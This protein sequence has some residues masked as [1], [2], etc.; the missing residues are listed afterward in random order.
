M[1]AESGTA[2]CY[3]VDSATTPGTPIYSSVADLFCT[4]NSLPRP[5][6]T[7]C[8][9]VEGSCD[10]TCTSPS[11]SVPGSC[12]DDTKWTSCN[13]DT[14]SAVSST[15]SAC[16]VGING[17]FT[18]NADAKYCHGVKPV[19]RA[20]A[21]CAAQWL[22]TTGAADTDNPVVCGS[23]SCSCQTGV[24][25]TAGGT[26]HCYI[27]G[28]AG[29][30]EDCAA[31]TPRP[32]EPGAD[33]TCAPKTCPILCRTI[34]TGDPP[35]TQLVACSGTNDALFGSCPAA[36]QCG[37]AIIEATVV[38]TDGAGAAA[39]NG[40]T[41]CDDTP[42]PV[43]ADTERACS[44]YTG[45]GQWQCRPTVPGSSGGSTLG[46]PETCELQCSAGCGTG[47]ENF[48]NGRPLCIVWTSGAGGAEPT[49]EVK[50]D[51]DAFCP[52]ENTASV[53]PVDA[54]ACTNHTECSFR[55][56]APDA[57]PTTVP[58]VCSAT[59]ATQFGPCVATNQCGTG[60]ASTSFACF[61]ERAQA[62]TASDKDCEDGAVTP[63]IAPS[64]PCEVFTGCGAW[65]CATQPPEDDDG[66]FVP[67]LATCTLECPIGCGSAVQVFTNGAPVCVS[68]DGTTILS[69]A[70][71]I[72]AFCPEAN[73]DDVK[74]ALKQC[75]D[76][77]QCARYC[78]LP[79][80][81]TPT[82]A[83]A[84]ADPV[85]CTDLTAWLPCN[86]AN[87]C[88]AGTLETLVV[89]YDVKY[90]E[91]RATAECAAV[92]DQ[93]SNSPCTVYEGCG[94][95]RCRT[96]T[97]ALD[98]CVAS[99][100]AGC[101]PST[102]V[103]NGDVT[104]ARQES[105]DGAWI[106]ASATE[107]CPLEN[108]APPTEQQCLSTSSCVWQ[109]QLAD[110]TLGT[111]DPNTM[112]ECTDTKWPPCSA[113]CGFGSRSRFVDCY[114]PAT[115][116][117]PSQTM[118]D[119]YC[120]ATAAPAET[121]TCE[122]FAECSFG[123]RCAATG[124]AT[125][126]PCDND[127]KFSICS[128]DCG[129][130]EQT[131]EVACFDHLDNRRDDK[132]CTAN[133][134]LAVQAC[135]GTTCSYAWGCFSGTPSLGACT[136]ENA[137]WG[138]CSATC[139]TGSRTRSTA[140]FTTGG[141]LLTSTASCV[142]DQDLAVPVTED[143]NCANYS[144]CKWAYSDWT[145]CPCRA[146]PTAPAPERSRT[147]TCTDAAGASASTDYCNNG[148]AGTAVTSETCLDA[149]TCD[150][151]VT[152]LWYSEDNAWTSCVGV[153][154]QC[155]QT[156]PVTCRLASVAKGVATDADGVLADSFCALLPRPSIS[157]VT[158]IATTCNAPS[159]TFST[160][161][162]TLVPATQADGT[163]LVGDGSLMG[164][165]VCSNGYSGANCLTAPSVTTVTIAAFTPGAVIAPG[166]RVNLG[167]IF[168]G[169][170]A[171]QLWVTLRPAGV[172]N[173]IPTT[174]AK[175]ISA[176]AQSFT[177]TIPAS[178]TPG[179][180]TLRL[181]ISDNVYGSANVIVQSKCAA[182]ANLCGDHGTCVAATGACVCRDGYTGSQCATSPCD[183]AQC[184]VV[185]TASC[186]AATGTCVCASGYV[187]GSYRCLTPEVCATAAPQCRN[188]GVAVAGIGA[189]GST[190]CA[191]SCRCFG[192][193]TGTFCDSCSL[194][195]LN[196]IA[197][198]ACSACECSPGYMVGTKTTCTCRFA[199]L[200]LAF[201]LS[202]I[203]GVTTDAT[204]AA[205]W[206][207]ALERDVNLQLDP[208]GT[209]AML[210]TVMSSVSIVNNETD[211]VMHTLRVRMWCDPNFETGFTILAEDADAA[212]AAAAEA[213]A[214]AVVGTAARIHGGAF[215]SQATDGDWRL[216]GAYQRLNAIKEAVE[217]RSLP[218]DTPLGRIA[219]NAG[220]GLSDEGCTDGGAACPTSSG[221]G[222]VL[223]ADPEKEPEV[224]L[225]EDSSSGLSSSG[226]LIVILCVVLGT[227]ALVG[228]I[229]LI[230]KCMGLC[231]FKQLTRPTR[232]ISYSVGGYGH[233]PAGSVEMPNMYGTRQGSKGR[234]PATSWS[235]RDQDAPRMPWNI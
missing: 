34:A 41:W 153:C 130:G 103:F 216:Y 232:R 148:A 160:G 114:A 117:T 218:A 181:H 37:S 123:W 206:T 208:T 23:S 56:V 119:S 30:R 214:R 61:D 138:P 155:V 211:Y 51:Q 57:A 225:E 60:V 199:T 166:V 99:C 151:D 100:P 7:P 91:A 191:D 50:D 89:C 13:C 87:A 69:E 188:G 196:G 18:P 36:N 150:E 16:S 112:G 113:R 143:I 167:W 128:V 122:A 192:S 132:Y 26:P 169:L 194:T 92:P 33:I 54:S 140:C 14:G 10:W 179:T 198:T 215:A 83:A 115:A 231:C 165:C 133:K 233:G 221:M 15:S 76:R 58:Q 162:C 200:R 182:T 2:H 174:V 90:N 154:G 175:D 235:P 3:E 161:T 184:N 223:T 141:I 159:V 107:F 204:Q 139:G 72:I 94:T 109:C 172:I 86:A 48:V 68:P 22:C 21:A 129:M 97:G 136:G 105:A 64:Q 116:D 197:N 163:T 118:S 96:S 195:C 185:G 207:A 104:C 212:A 219:Y 25:S 17:A 102:Q 42:E 209:S 125:Y 171:Q 77:T 228:I 120:S 35:S 27:A 80:S 147:A 156:R 157:R 101:G 24:V 82:Q 8:E 5:V 217:S 213:A 183:A 93:P 222:G 65:K 66:S 71:D 31:A 126:E 28:V 230:A 45:C 234:R 88:G 32:S 73:T 79:D 205:Q 146:S 210:A 11:G 226:K 152:P 39:P 178:L 111:P 149:Y 170:A 98:E 75:S 106:A 4:D 78:V 220:V 142:N 67:A 59:D 203:P 180:Y 177:T 144:G 164:S 186:T 168:N 12:T 62:R 74:P 127:A 19:T 193:F 53:K 173:P 47:T 201:P 49:F 63:P 108:G 38:C 52:S 190:A 46:D 227:A 202:A 131:R 70:D 43:A 110:D 135:Q 29:S 134:P 187:Q 6:D 1:V 55:C 158:Q 176:L 20:C 95:Y 84:G 229:V 81:A 40:S 137:V 121:S 44:L 224:P 9:P 124:D 189:A 85:P 145:E